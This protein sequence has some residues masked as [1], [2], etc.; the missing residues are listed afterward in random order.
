LENR[1]R[2]WV[3]EHLLYR[4]DGGF[5]GNQKNIAPSSQP[6][7]QIQIVSIPTQLNIM[8]IN[9]MHRY[10]LY[11]SAITTATGI[12]WPSTPHNGHSGAKFDYPWNPLESVACILWNRASKGCAPA[13]R[14][15]L[16]LARS[17]GWDNVS[18]NQRRED[19]T[20]V[21]VHAALSRQI[22]ARCL[23]LMAMVIPHAS[24]A[25][26][27]HESMYGTQCTACIECYLR[28]AIAVS[29]SVLAS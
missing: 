10:T 24:T 13:F 26:E 3:S 9:F 8:T 2:C 12:T 28:M 25:Q 29:S 22:T 7:S 4:I 1:E 14:L 11:Q 17:E 6:S 16:Q 27:R 19:L 20:V 21:A 5:S 15:Q 23:M 18:F